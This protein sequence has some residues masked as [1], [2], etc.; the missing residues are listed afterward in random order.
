MDC[1]RFELFQLADF[2][3]GDR[4][5]NGIHPRIGDDLTLLDPR[6]PELPP[7]PTPIHDTSAA[8]MF[9]ARQRAGCVARQLRRTARTYASEAH[10][11]H[12]AA[13]ANESFGVCSPNPRI[14]WGP[15]IGSAI[16]MGANFDGLERLDLR[17]QCLFWHRPV[18]P[19]RPRQGRGVGDHQ[20]HQQAPLSVRG[21]G[22]DQCSAHQGG[23]AGCLR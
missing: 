4:L 3:G 18:H 21:L 1:R 8:T 6:P 7:R 2:I 20:L 14:G 23:G 12:K 13:E 22:G 10:G 16:R 5:C 11:H 19:I 15:V 17:G 9:A